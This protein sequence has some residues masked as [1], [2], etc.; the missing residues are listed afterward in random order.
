MQMTHDSNQKCR[1]VNLDMETWFDFFYY[2]KL[3]R[4]FTKQKRDLIYFITK[5]KIAHLQNKETKYGFNNYWY[6]IS[7]GKKNLP[8]YFKNITPTSSFLQKQ[9]KELIFLAIVLWLIDWIYKQY[10]PNRST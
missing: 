2:Y 6:L 3:N 9:Y 10:V 7:L 8:V 1:M 4:S 5:N